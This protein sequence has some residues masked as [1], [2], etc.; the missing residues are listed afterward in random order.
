[1]SDRK[2]LCN[3]IAKQTTFSGDPLKTTL[4]NTNRQLSWLIAIFN[5]YNLIDHVFFFA[6]G[7]DVLI[8]CEKDQLKACEHAL[9]SVY[10]TV[11]DTGSKGN[12]LILKE[13]LVSEDRFTFLSKVGHVVNDGGQRKLLYRRT[14]E[15]LL[16]TGET[17]VTPGLKDIPAE[18]L[19]WML[20][21]QLLEQLHGDV[22]LFKILRW[23]LERLPMR[24]ASK[25]SQAI[26]S[27]GSEEWFKRGMHVTH[28][29][30]FSYC[31]AVDP[32]YMQLVTGTD[33]SRILRNVYTNELNVNSNISSLY[34]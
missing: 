12:G 28:R 26:F 20:Y 30:D 11:G 7:D 32:L 3:F 10:C 21:H 27:N 16:R 29:D 31:A 19:R 33:P 2:F 34:L 4:G 5:H 13:I 14:V 15:R 1:M 23:R 9:K 8:I 22:G 18:E 25:K 6:S 17:S 24:P